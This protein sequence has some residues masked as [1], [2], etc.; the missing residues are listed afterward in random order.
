MFGLLTA[1]AWAAPS[2]YLP[3]ES[4]NEW[5]Y[6][7]NHLS[8]NDFV[9]VKVT[10]A[11]DFNGHTYFHLVGQPIGERW[12]RMAEDGTVFSVDKEGGPETVWAYFGGEQGSTYTS[13][14]DACSPT[15]MVESTAG[16]YSGSLGAFENSFLIRYPPA[17]CRDAGL[18]QDVFLPG[19]GLVRRVEQT[20]AGPR[21]YD[22]IY[23][24]MGAVTSISDSRL[25]FSLGLDRCVYYGSSAG[26]R[27]LVAVA[28][29]TLTARENPVTLLF[30]SGQSFDL[31][32]HHEKGGEVYRWSSGKA[33]TM[34]LREEVVEGERNWA[35]AAELGKLGPGKYTAEAWLTTMDSGKKFSATVG[36][37]I[38]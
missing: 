1:S 16:K 24:R 19:V 27:P 7:V 12:L 23:T 3:L 29:L 37:E 22:L 18:E 13:T 14:A 6:R 5:I 31:A 26:V 28:R 20:I 38:R 32:V 30:S 2:D 4:G 33:F 35:L 11:K 15:A 9:T 34:A 25:S 36:F 10:A 17:S 8:G 21:S